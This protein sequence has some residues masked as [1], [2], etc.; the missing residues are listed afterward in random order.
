MEQEKLLADIAAILHRL[1]IP[2]LITG[3]VAVVVW[4]RPRFTA[5]I[6]LV[7]EIA[8]RK[9]A[10]LA[11]AL[12]AI[13][14]DVYL[15]ERMMQ[16]ALETQGEFNFIHPASGLKVDFW[17]LTRSMFDKERMRRRVRRRFIGSNIYLSSPEDL[18]LIKLLW[19]KKTES[20]RQLE[21]IESVIQIQ[22]KL[23]WRYMWKW[24]KLQGTYHILKQLWQTKR[25]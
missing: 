6:D 7:V 25:K 16:K 17:V 2:Y 20:T 19:Y 14:K 18:I 12:R 1:Q 13:D 5:D 3:G 24:A 9:L 22:K 21:D 23:N 8:P 10:P 15:D 11:S 4:G